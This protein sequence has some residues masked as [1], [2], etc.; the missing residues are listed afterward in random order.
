MPTISYR[1]PWRRPLLVIVSSISVVFGSIQFAGGQPPAEDWLQFHGP[2][3]DNISHETG[4]LKKWPDDGP[5]L[6]WRTGGIGH[7]WATVA[8]AA[9]RI[10]TAGDIGDRTVITALDLDGKK[11][12]Q[13]ENGPAYD[14]Q[15]PGARGTPTVADD[16]IYHLSGEG[17]LRCFEAR[18]GSPVWSLDVLEYFKGRNIQWGLAESVTVDGDKVICCPGGEKVGVAALD[19]GTG[20]TLWTCEGIGDKPA[21]TSGIVVDFGGLRQFITTMSASAVGVEIETGRLLWRY[22]R[23]APFD[24]NVA[25]PVY[26]DGHVAIS[27][28]WGRGTTL[29]KLNVDGRDCSVEAV[30]HNP[31]FDIEHGGFVLVEGHLYGLADGNH[32]RRHWAC[33]D[34]RTGEI[35]YD[36]AAPGKK[37]AATSYADGMLY[38]LGD[39]RTV[40]LVPA[41]RERFEVVSQFELP[42][43]PEGPTWA[44]PVI[45]GGR[46][47]LRHS[48]WLYV[49]GVR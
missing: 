26:H 7:G 2:R 24:V 48:D 12:W 33:A 35:T 19:K 49:Y 42:R 36:S 38:L 41:T 47:Y 34:W 39:D 30:W 29:L 3:R 15:F 27:T 5:E 20:Q 45:H 44:H 23:E 37:S 32:R 31:E 18:T 4:L 16:R 14:R 10:Y 13:Q 43:G 17:N 40:A 11:V 6:L 9:G 28:T 46:L 1:C 22:Q 21:Y 25:T 8:I